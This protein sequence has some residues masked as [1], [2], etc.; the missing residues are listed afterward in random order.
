MT[1]NII[2]F[3][4]PVID[5]PF[6]FD[7]LIDYI[8]DEVFTLN[9][10]PEEAVTEIFDSVRGRLSEVAEMIGD[11]IKVEGEAPPEIPPEIAVQY[12]S[13]VLQGAGD[14][15]N[16]VIRWMIVVV[17]KQEIDIWCLVHIGNRPLYES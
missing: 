10:L 9:K 11:A 13:E 3:P 6:S 2:K 8:R 16:R 1:D 14:Q 4:V 5:Q 15:L 17:V 7:A 12:A